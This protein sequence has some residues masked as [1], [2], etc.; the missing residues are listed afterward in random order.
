[1]YMLCLP[2]QPP[3]PADAAS[4]SS[5]C[6]LISVTCF[7]WFR[8]CQDLSLSFPDV[9]AEDAE[10]ASAFQIIRGLVV[11]LPGH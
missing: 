2:I 7:P 9:C 11:R 4:C 10:D 1:M 6:H 3:F 5:T 8:V